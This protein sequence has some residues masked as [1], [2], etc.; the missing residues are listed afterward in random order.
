HYPLKRRFYERRTINDSLALLDRYPVCSSANYVMS[1]AGGQ[2]LDV[3]ST[4]A[5]YATLDDA[6]EGFIVHS[7]HFLSPKFATAETL[8]KS[9]P[10]SC[11]R[12]S[13]MRELIRA[14]FGQL[15][16]AHFQRFLADHDGHPTSISRHAS[17]S[18]RV[19]KSAAGLIAKPE[20]GRF[21]VC[22]G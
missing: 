3:E 12:Y 10:D 5:G 9:I 1:G 11:N 2:I 13:R 15:T 8:A 7:N 14:E 21:H 16:V 18:D 17:E 19:G 4:P 20:A 6:G 22:R